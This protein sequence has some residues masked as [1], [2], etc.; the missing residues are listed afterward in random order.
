MSIKLYKYINNT[1]YKDF[2]NILVIGVVHGDEPYGEYFI[3][4]YIKDNCGSK[5]NN[6]YYIPRLNSSPSRK[7]KN[8]VDIN[9]NFP[10]KNW[11]KTDKN[12]DYFGGDYPNSEEETQF[13]VDLMDKIKFDG[14][15]TIHSPYKLVNYDGKE[16]KNT[17]KLADKIASYLGYKTEESIGYPTPG[18]FGTYAGV[19]RN[20]PTITIE[21]DENEEKEKLYEKFKKIFKYLENEF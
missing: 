11:E 19:E 16:N 15:I 6:L 17:I 10:T 21:Y 13:I 8:G 14:I 7:N 1:D 2:K 5:K 12:S 18:S 4:K 9:R 20:I 3:E